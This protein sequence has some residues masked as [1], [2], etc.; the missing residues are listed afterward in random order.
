MPARPMKPMNSPCPI[1]SGQGGPIVEMARPVAIISAPPITVQRVPMRSAIWPIMMPPS[2][3]PSQASE[4]AS[5]GI[6]RAPPTSAAMSL[7]ATAVIQLAPNA[8]I[9]ANSATKATTQDARDFN[10]SGIAACVRDSGDSSLAHR[11]GFDHCATGRAVVRQTRPRDPTGPARR[12]RFRDAAKLAVLVP[13]TTGGRNSRAKNAARRPPR[14][15]SLPLAWRAR[16]TRAI[17]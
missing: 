13:A 9:S 10:G 16:N 14:A 17:C 2:P 3:E 1:H 8:I 12:I 4:L 15:I 7:S 11:R 6:E 5:A